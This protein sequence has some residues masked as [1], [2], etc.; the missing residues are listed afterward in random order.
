M[1]E[2]IFLLIILIITINYSVSAQEGI[3][4]DNERH[5]EYSLLYHGEDIRGIIFLLSGYNWGEA[6]TIGVIQTRKWPRV[7]FCRFPFWR[8]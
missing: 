1:K 4:E 3:L 8:C 5:E 2:R 7:C 6:G